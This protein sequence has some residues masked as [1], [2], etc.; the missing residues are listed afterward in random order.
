[1]ADQW[2]DFLTD[3]AGALHVHT[4]KSNGAG[5]L[6]EVVSAAE[7]AGLRF[8]IITDH[9]TR[10]YAEE[11]A[12]G[13]QQSVLVLVGEEISIGVSRF[14]ILGHA[15]R[16]EG[17]TLEATLRDAQRHDALVVA[18]PPEDYTSQLPTFAA[19]GEEPPTHPRPIPPPPAPRLDEHPPPLEL[20]NG[21]EFW[22]G[23]EDWARGRADRKPM[24]DPFQ[25]AE[26]IGLQGPRRGAMRMWDELTLKGRILGFA[27]LNAHG[28]SWTSTSP[29]AALPYEILFRSLTTHV[30]TPELPRE[31]P[32]RARQILLKALRAG[33]FHTAHSS[34][35]SPQGFRF[36]AVGEELPS[37]L[38][39][40]EAHYNPRYQLQVRLPQSALIKLI[41][42]GSQLLSAEG[43]VLEC[44]VIGPGVY[45]VEA[46]LERR[47]WIFSNPIWLHPPG[48]HRKST[49][50]LELEA[51]LLDDEGEHYSDLL[52]SAT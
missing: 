31:S 4:V 13:W 34:I 26:H 25:R 48:T 24:T 11:G 40:D 33:H 35:A 43:E 50:P 49:E 28:R 41:Y 47:P 6:A 38:Q 46:W 12:E 3:Q 22:C 23:L 1:M 36:I 32:Q 51:A 7:R 30:L 14:I 5:T 52:D 20:V 37:L 9:E 8:L 19:R 2:F 39:G 44:P 15:S 10:G 29:G 42:N 21:W 18:L 45:R 27:G 16:L 17:D